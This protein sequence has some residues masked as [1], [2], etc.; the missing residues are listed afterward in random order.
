MVRRYPEPDPARDEPLQFIS[1]W[2][3]ERLIDEAKFLSV[4]YAHVL[5][6]IEHRAQHR[7]P[8]SQIG[9]AER[10]LTRH[11]HEVEAQIEQYLTDAH[12]PSECY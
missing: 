9:S 6:E 7:P 12:P 10:C 5:G 8:D 4:L 3:D 1:H 11:R 2:S